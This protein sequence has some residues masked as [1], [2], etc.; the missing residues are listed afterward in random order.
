MTTSDPRTKYPRP[1]ERGFTLIELLVTLA[2]IGIL[3]LAA[4]W[5]AQSALAN[6]ALDGA[7]RTI[8]GDIATCKGL[9]IKQNRAFR[10]AFTPG[11][12]TTYQLLQETAPSSGVFQNYLTAV[13]IIP[14]TTAA[15]INITLATN[16]AAPAANTMEFMPRGTV[17]S[18]GTVTLNL[19]SG[20]TRRIAT[21]GIG[22]TCI[23]E[24]DTGCTAL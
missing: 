8:T 14:E 19:P 9:A 22:R 10:I 15:S 5:S 16:Y 17:T 1:S 18:A 7:V 23:V 11:T 13:P 20:Q 24:T 4:I 2:I 3:V 12:N 6:R 21:N